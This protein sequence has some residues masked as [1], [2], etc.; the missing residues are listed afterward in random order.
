MLHKN[1][2]DIMKAKDKIAIFSEFGYGNDTLC[3][4]EVEKGEREYRIRGFVI[5]P[6]VEGIYLRIWVGKRVVVFSTK[7]IFSWQS[8]NKNRI[9]ILFGLQGYKCA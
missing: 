7:N 6:K 8:K 4:T 2:I 9:K 3:S 5:P 1:I